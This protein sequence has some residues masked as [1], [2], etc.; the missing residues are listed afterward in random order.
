MAACNLFG[1]GCSDEAT[2][3]IMMGAFQALFTE[4]GFEVDYKALAQGMPSRARLTQAEN[5]LATD[6][7]IKVIQ[8]IIKDG[9]KKLGLITNACSIR[10]C[11]QR[12]STRRP[13]T[14]RPRTRATRA[15]YKPT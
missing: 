8:E 10:A 5:E 11:R 4:I 7:L 2:I 9:A 15:L 12:S 6:C 1:Y 14:C 3:T 13:A